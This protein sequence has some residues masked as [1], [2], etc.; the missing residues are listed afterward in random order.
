MSTAAGLDRL[1]ERSRRDA[2]LSTAIDQADVIRRH[3]GR[4]AWPTVV[5]CVGLLATYA[6]T[7]AAWLA[8][9]LPLWTGCVINSALS[10]ALFTVHHDANHKAISGRKAGWRW[11]DPVLGTIAGVPLQFSYRG[12][13]A[14][15]LRHHAHTNHPS[16][17]PDAFLVGAVW[18]VPL[19]W[20]AAVIL[21]TVSS[22]PYC[23]PLEAKVTARFAPD[24][25]PEPSARVVLEMR[26]NRRAVQIGTGVLLA[27]IPLGLF[28]PVFFLWWLP[29]RIGALALMVF[30]SWLPHMPFDSTARFRN[31]RIN[32]FRGST[33]LLLHQDRHLI[34]HLY[35]S[36]P[37][38]RYRAVFR[39]VRPLLEAEGARIEGRDSN[40]HEAITLRVV[41]R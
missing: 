19:K 6:T 26:R 22:L 13:T 31:T 8:G 20:F 41:N 16:R 38:Y 7:V 14:Q 3:S 25:V 29:G 2:L 18:T 30:F 40:T 5:L 1:S 24:D 17:D 15:H 9:G 35:P 4:V 28:A 36:V 10:Y 34:H 32:T 39:E 11:L 37:W 33:W 27:S 23:G 21:R 12:F